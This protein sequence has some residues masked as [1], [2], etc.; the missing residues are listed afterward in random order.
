MSRRRGFTLLE[1]LVALAIVGA[2]LAL[3]LGSLRV[4]LAAWRQGDE[5][6]EAHA[7]LRS[8]SELLARSVAA[9]F[10]YR[11][12]GPEGG[13]PQLQFKC[14][15]GHLSLVTFAPPFPLPD[16]VAFT[17]VS[18]ARQEGERPGLAI[19]QKALPN[20]E[21]FEETEPIFVDA[22]VTGLTFRCLGADG[23]WDSQEKQELPR[24]VEISLT[25]SLG[26]R[27]ETLPPL[28]ISIP[29]R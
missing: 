15:E 11:Q 25:A 20:F 8:L 18:F 14:E 6:A 17:A 21:P 9:A 24:A 22:S 13:Q 28:T 27:T 5:R 4:G 16:P 23:S 26:G 7:H 3:A 19:R 29:A 2:L 12:S 1:L 10:P